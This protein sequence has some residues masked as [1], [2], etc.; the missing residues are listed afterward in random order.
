MSPQQ[1]RA[2][3]RYRPAWFLR[4]CVWY[5]LSEAE[6]CRALRAIAE[7]NVHEARKHLARCESELLKADGAVRLF[8][9][10]ARDAGVELAARRTA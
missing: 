6:S 3:L 7:S 1:L 10:Q 4:L 5:S 9:M 2:L 8:D